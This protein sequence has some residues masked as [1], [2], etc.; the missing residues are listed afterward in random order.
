MHITKLQYG[1][2]NCH[3]QKVTLNDGKYNLF[4]KYQ[5]NFTI[6][7]ANSKENIQPCTKP[8]LIRKK[9]GILKSRVH[10]CMATDD[11]RFTKQSQGKTPRTAP[12]FS[13]GE[14]EVTRNKPTRREQ[15]G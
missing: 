15:Q 6:W 5:Y 2:C 14:K 1:V 9:I 7:A 13:Q 11:L 8:F 10:L 12:N 3:L 4:I